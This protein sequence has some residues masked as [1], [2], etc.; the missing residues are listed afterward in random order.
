MSPE[1]KLSNSPWEWLGSFLKEKPWLGFWKN[2][3]SLD[4]ILVLFRETNKIYI[5]IYY[6]KWLMWLRN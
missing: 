4:N 6:K 5:E 3:F 2:E 1:E